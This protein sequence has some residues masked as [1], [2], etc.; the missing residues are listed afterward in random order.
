MPDQ[1]APLQ[2]LT[3]VYNPTKVE[4]LEAV[5]SVVADACARHGWEAPTWVA[6]TESETGEAQARAAVESGAD[7]VGSLGGD[8]TV[9]AVATALVGTDVSLGLLPGGTGN[10]LARNLGLPVDSMEEAAEAMLGGSGRRI[11]VGMV[12][13]GE[14]SAAPEEVFLVMAGLGLDGEIM[15]G[16]NEKI[17]GALGWPAY[18]IAATK[19]LAKRGFSV[20][21]R[22]SGGDGVAG[23]PGGEVQ[24]HAR[25]VIVGNCGTLQGGIDLMPDARLDDGRLDVV[26]LAPQGLAGWVSVMADVVTRHRQGHSRLDR[27]TGAEITVTAQQPVEA[28]IDGDPVGPHRELAARV[29]AQ[30]LTV[31]VSDGTDQR[32]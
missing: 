3:V 15:A 18:V 12:R 32:R 1:T 9:R 26:V 19:N 6:T 16:T 22:S 21:V 31:R 29:L 7:V 11:D 17:K 27:V 4:D 13:L 30:A 23:Q 5:Q 2:R 10:L 24:R 14:A 8:G 20:T 28:E 25:T